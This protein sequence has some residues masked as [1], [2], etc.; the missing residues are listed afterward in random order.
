MPTAKKLTSGS[1]RCQ[2]FSHFED[3]IGKDGKLKKK[4][5]YKSFTCDD[6]SKAGKREAE[7]MAAEWAAKKEQYAHTNNQMMLFS[8]AL[9]N[10]ISERSKILSP[11]SIRKYRSMERN[12]MVPFERYRLKDL[13]QDVVQKE[14]NLAASEKSPKTIRDMHGL[15]TAVLARFCPEVVLRTTMPKRV[16][17]DIHIPSDD[18]IRRLIATAEGTDMEIP[19]YLAAFGALR[20]GEIAALSYQDITGNT[21]H[22]HQTMV[23]SAEG[24]WV[25]KAPKSYAGDRYVTLPEFVTKKIGTGTGLITDLRPNMITSR[26]AHILKQSGLPPFRF[27][28]LRHYNASILH[29]LGIPDAYIMQAGG[30]G[31]D[32]TLKEVYRHTLQATTDL[33]NNV[34]VS[35]FE[36]LMK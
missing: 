15:L 3:V 17:A 19:I 24:E 33:F 34:A 32:R 28:S 29:A 11:A 1:W 7:R 21:V 25:T 36:Q 4:R 14:I 9:D 6:P 35:H 22:V 10:Y 31:N 5:K 27:H 13:T 20:R 26:F 30:W 23:L 18:D 8:Q 16:H 12:C 2:V